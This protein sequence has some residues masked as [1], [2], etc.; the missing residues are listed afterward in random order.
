M[1]GGAFSLPPTPLLP[2]SQQQLIYFTPVEN[3]KKKK[4]PGNMLPSAV[5][6]P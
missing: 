6:G 2:E 1:A 5:T 3:E 4:L